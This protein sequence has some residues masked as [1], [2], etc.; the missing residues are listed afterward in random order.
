MAA[1]KKEHIEKYEKLK[2]EKDALVD[3]TKRH[4]IEAYYHAVDEVL[5]EEGKKF[6]KKKT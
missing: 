6:P 2:K 1:K 5:T 4:H 3:L